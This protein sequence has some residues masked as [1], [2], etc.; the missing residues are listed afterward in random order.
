[1]EKQLA[2]AAGHAMQSDSSLKHA[3]ACLG[4]KGL[5]SSIRKMILQGAL[6]ESCA[7]RGQDSTYCDG[8]P[9]ATV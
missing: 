9:H 3:S 1:M 8:S 4:A 2:L 5:V 6:A 7:F